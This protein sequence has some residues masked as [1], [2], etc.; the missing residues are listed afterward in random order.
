M[1]KNTG[2]LTLAVM[3]K[4]LAIIFV[5]SNMSSPGP[6]HTQYLFIPLQVLCSL[7]H[8]SPVLRHI[9]S[10][11]LGDTSPKLV[12]AKAPTNSVCR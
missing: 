6:R 4:L 2:E 5:L 1:W 12:E 8:G 3:Y 7:S 10:F 11:R 9:G